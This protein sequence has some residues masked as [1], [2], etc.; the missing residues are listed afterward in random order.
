MLTLE[1]T[2][3]IGVNRSVSCASEHVSSS[4]GAS[5]LPRRADTFGGF[6]SQQRSSV[7]LSQCLHSKVLF[8]VGLNLFPLAY[9]L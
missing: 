6:D 2:S 7:E 3:T 5:G 4:Y 9:F 1:D 8:Q